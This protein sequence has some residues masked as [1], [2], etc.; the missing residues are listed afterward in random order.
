MSVAEFSCKSRWGD[1]LALQRLPHPSLCWAK[2]LLQHSHNSLASTPWL[3]PSP[4]A[5]RHGAAFS[6]ALVPGPLCCG[7]QG[8]CAAEGPLLPCWQR[9]GLPARFRCGA[10][11]SSSLLFSLGPCNP[12][13]GVSGV[14]VCSCIE[15]GAHPSTYGGEQGL[16]MAV[17]PARAIT[18]Q[19]ACLRPCESMEAGWV[20]CMLPPS[21]GH[22]GS[23]A[24]QPGT[25]RACP[26][27]GDH[28]L[29]ACTLQQVRVGWLNQLPSSAVPT[30]HSIPT[31]GMVA[32]DVQELLN[33]C[34]L[35][36]STALN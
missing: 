5:G 23:A 12:F 33:C 3:R 11:G 18:L 35:W 29:G 34:K 15:H 14:D 4:G 13:P 28:S 8:S 30:L 6:P 7:T 36:Q 17:V 26:T 20:Q 27:G 32:E 9:E 10:A 31:M 2:A 22:G 1:P 16:G 24:A 21:T 19:G 25:R